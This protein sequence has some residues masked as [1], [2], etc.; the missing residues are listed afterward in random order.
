MSDQSS[1]DPLPYTQVDRAA[2][3]QASLL[4]GV[5]KSTYQ[6][7]LGSVVEFWRLNS[8]P[9]VLEQL[10]LQAE[11]DGREPEVVLSRE[12]VEARFE[13]ASGHRVSAP[14]LRELSLIELRED[15]HARVRGMSRAFE[16]IQRRI[17]AKRAAS[18]GGKKSAEV[19]RA[20]TGSAQP[21]RSTSASNAAQATLEAAPKRAR[22]GAEAGFEAAP[23]T[24]VSGQRSA[25][26][27]E[28]TTLSAGADDVGPPEVLKKLW[29]EK[30]RHRM[31][32][33]DELN[34]SRRTRAI[35]RWREHPSEG[36]WAQL[37]ERMATSLFCSG[38]SS[39]FKATF[40]WILKPANLT[41]VLEGNY[42]NGRGANGG[43]GSRNDQ[44][45]NLA[46][47][48]NSWGR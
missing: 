1:S 45:R 8:D 6:H 29:N 42:D 30:A 28:E 32:R 16:P 41:K 11:K 36:F 39:D 20:T 33:I 3:P 5:L 25:T 34:D 18:N 44:F 19:R 38:Q 31:P 40:D 13:V 9:R 17:Q 46:D 15:G 21:P 22:S 35:A 23:N 37:F 4:A 24:A 12:E 2:L 47:G 10:V 7:A 26:A 14:I 48:E 43:T 27:S